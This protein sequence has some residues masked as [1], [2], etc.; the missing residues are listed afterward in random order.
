MKINAVLQALNQRP[1]AYMPAYRDLAGSIAG[2]VLLSQIMY[3]WA[4]TGGRKFYKTDAELMAETGL[5]KKELETA[6]KRVKELNF[7]SVSLEGMPAR[8]Y[9]DVDEEKLASALVE[10]VSPNRGNKVPQI[11]ETCLSL[12][13]ETDLTENTTETTT[14]PPLTPPTPGGT[15]VEPVGGGGEARAQTQPL[16]SGRGLAARYA[17]RAEEVRIALS[18]PDVDLYVR[19]RAAL[20]EHMSS[21]HAYRRWLAEAV[22]PELQRLGPRAFRA[23]VAEAAPR[24]VDPAIKHPTAWLLKRLQ[25]AEPPAERRWNVSQMWAGLEYR[26]VDDD[27]HPVLDPVSEEERDALLARGLARWIG[28]AAS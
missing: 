25:Q 6:K 22:W 3:W 9:Y 17:Q 23:A 19:F 12:N 16:P 10:L 5:S 27:G 20:R 13:G 26:P 21:E 1:V 8:T 14:P 11:G 15:G 2:G 28:E 7:I 24:L 18:E 4:A